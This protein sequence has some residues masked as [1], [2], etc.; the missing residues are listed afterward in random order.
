MTVKAQ[1][2][3]STLQQDDEDRKRL[4][5]QADEQIIH[6]T[7][8]HWIVLF[9]R[10]LI[11]VLFTLFFA[12]L[13]FYRA[14]G[15]TFLSAASRA[16][17][18]FD[19]LNYVLSVVLGLLILFWLIL[20]VRSSK[21]RQTRTVL[22]AVMGMLALLIYYRA[23]GGRF[24]YIDPV[25]ASLQAFDGWNIV[26][27]VCAGIA[28][29][30]VGISAYD[31]Q[32]DRLVLTTKRVIYDDD[33]VLIPR[34]LERRSQ[35]E[36]DIDDIQAV[37]AT[38]KTY[39]QHWLKYGLIIVKSASYAGSIEFKAATDPKQ[40]QGKIMGE[41]NAHRKQ[42]SERDF[43]R[44]IEGEVY[45]V[46]PA[47]P[48]VTA[49]V[50]HTGP[51]KLLRWIFPENPERD[52][53]KNEITWRQ[54]W[55]FLLQAIGLPLT[56]F[57]LAVVSVFIAAQF[58]WVSG[59]LVTVLLLV[60]LIGCAL[61]L[62]WEIEDYRNDVYILTGSNIIDVQKKPFGPEDRRTAPIENIQ[63]VSFTTS[64]ISNL[65]NYG[66]VTVQTAS[67]GEFTFTR[68]PN[69]RSVVG[70]INDYRRQ[71]ENGKKARSMS[72]MLTLLRHYHAAQIKHNEIG[73]GGAKP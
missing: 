39:P 64:F 56:V 1:A 13:A 35:Q 28:L 17:P 9:G 59:P 3:T 52:E 50:V 70:I 53:A 6:E 12:G 18:G 24:F 23:Q 38:T 25:Y 40:M 49:R 61:W 72:D 4:N 47:K 26:L 55:L 71:V 31:W 16:E 67:S 48:A 11:P 68:V 62:A 36:V 34:L 30:F 65:F 43:E 58:L 45:G 46:K 22:V 66:N 37:V 44:M 21:D 41:V 15:G 73:N 54:H 57:F 20:W 7:R 5:L 63:N 10:S 32:N 19:L 69:P 8:T 42:N 14:A 33:L 2:T 51:W 27:M 29:F 60:L